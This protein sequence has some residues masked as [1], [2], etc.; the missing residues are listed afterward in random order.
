M[1]HDSNG[2]ASASAGVRE[3][4]IDFIKRWEIVFDGISAIT[5]SNRIWI[6]TGAVNQCLF[7]DVGNGTLRDFCFIC[8]SVRVCILF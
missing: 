6:V 4:L 5:F 7:L 1:P 2:Y 8:I 3:H